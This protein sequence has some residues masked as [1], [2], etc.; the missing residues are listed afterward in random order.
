VVKAETQVAV[1]IPTD[2]AFHQE[3]IVKFWA[4][5]SYTACE[6]HIVLYM[7]KLNVV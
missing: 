1:L 3:E 6:S 7:E 2:I 4:S 5:T